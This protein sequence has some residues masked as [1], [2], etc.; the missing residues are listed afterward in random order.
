MHVSA[1]R[2]FGWAVP[3]A[4]LL[5]GLV[6][7]V[8]DPM[9]G[10]AELDAQGR[11]VTGCFGRWAPEQSRVLK[12]IREIEATTL[13]KTLETL[14]KR[15]AGDPKDVAARDLLGRAYLRR[16]RPRDAINQ[17]REALAVDPAHASSRQALAETYLRLGRRASAA[18]ELAE[19]VRS[20][21]GAV[22]VRS[23]LA[24]LYTRMGRH[25]DAAEQL[26]EVARE[27]PDDLQAQVRLAHALLRSGRPD[28]A[29]TVVE[30]ELTR[31][32]G[33]VALRR[34]LAD[35]RR[36]Q[37]DWAG[38]ARELTALRGKGR[39]DA[40]AEEQLG[41]VH[42]HQGD[43]AA[44]RTA[45][46]AAVDIETRR[47]LARG[48]LAV[49]A[50]GAGDFAGAA[51]A[52]GALRG[53][54]PP[55]L[56][57]H[58]SLAGFLLANVWLAKGDRTAV[59][60]ACGA[61]PDRRPGLES[62]YGVIFEAT[63]DR[64]EAR[65]DVAFRLSL[66]TLSHHAGWFNE[67]IA[68]VGP[69]RKL[70]PRSVLVADV[71]S[72]CYGAAGRG[73][74]RLALWEE[75]RTALPDDLNV[76]R[77]LANLY[78]A[79]RQLERAAEACRAV[80]EREP[81]DLAARLLLSSIALRRG[82]TGEA[83]RHAE[84]ARTADPASAAAYE[85][86]LDVL[87]AREALGEAARVAAARE[88]ADE[89]FVRGPLERAISAL[90]AGQPAEA[91]IQAEVGLK[92]TPYDLR[93][94]F[95]AGLALA[96][97]GDAAG[98]L[99]HF[100]AALAADPSFLPAKAHAARAALRVGEAARAAVLFR[101]VLAVQPGRLDAQLGMADALSKLGRPADAIAGLRDIAGPLA[102][103][104]GP[105]WRAIQARL[106]KEYLAVGEASR[107]LSTADAVLVEAPGHVEAART[108]AEAHRRL[109]GL[110]GA[111]RV[112]E[113]LI[114]RDP[115]AP[116]GAE[117][118]V[119]RF[120][121]GRA[122]DA[123][124]LLEA[125]SREATPAERIDLL[126]WLAAARVAAGQPDKAR[127]PIDE[128]F[129]RKGTGR[130]PTALLALIL[131]AS[132]SSANAARELETLRA[133]SGEV[134]DWAAAAASRLRREP[135]LAAELLGGLCAGAK[136]WPRRA[137]ERIASARDR[138]SDEPFVLYLAVMRFRGAKMLGAA[139][140]AARDLV[141]SRPKSGLARLQLAQLLDAQGRPQDAV[142]VYLEVPALLPKR[143]A[144]LWA[145]VAQRLASGGKI[146]EAI[147]AYRTVLGIDAKMP[148]ACNNLAWL[149]A[150]H[151]PVFLGDA[152]MLAG[153]AAEA[154]PDVAAFHDTYGWIL[155]LRNKAEEARRELERANKLAPDTANYVYHLGMTLHKLGEADGARRLLHRAL[156]LD[157]KLP[158]AKVI[159]DILI[160]L[161]PD[162]SARLPDGP[163]RPTAP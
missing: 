149:Y 150:Q 18:K 120:L 56:D 132:G 12:A 53:L 59:R 78:Y 27:S 5:V 67:A 106:A 100:E 158:E 162:D 36:A 76:T 55:P 96:G 84:A 101:S 71:L 66:A 102:R 92:R 16:G 131:G 38:A 19:L 70:A 61:M 134:A 138:A 24:A 114:A 148:A 125:A 79:Q 135:G 124:G 110:D 91:L 113:R 48:G 136:G 139:T 34:L 7:A 153:R 15:V 42:L 88:K 122:G 25:V 3:I 157:P 85:A 54:K 89:R 4:V 117:L 83:L 60:A 80:V 82:D 163:P 50:L 159:R 86:S 29:Q 123:V 155:F 108:A 95:V 43:L 119:L 118:G 126:T 151:R 77:Q 94:H 130:P 65:R 9:W 87:L 144:T 97:R 47:V 52:C 133:A 98:A 109:G 1:R 141:R 62:A 74:E 129:K 147:E 39:R 93:L 20:N 2:R 156:K 28:R 6:D 75:L 146:D 11:R 81:N 46:Q 57:I 115:K 90:A 64:A 31:T 145:A 30:A 10:W 14:A 49:A 142:K 69:A 154:M 104:G 111:T 41:L 161:G 63:G 33:S 23:Q 107:A 35:C 121:E 37:G 112:Y 116:V 140:R 137:L 128:V 13:D 72:T 99:P 44:A 32:P 105:R 68:A 21:P 22:R 103:E 160:L 26:S 152:E 127:A 17:F 40:A 45:F 51:A 8:A 73:A 143:D 58:Q